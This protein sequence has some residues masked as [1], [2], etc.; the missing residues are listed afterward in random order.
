M[1]SK[2]FSEFMSDGVGNDT[3]TQEDDVKSRN[4]ILS[5][6]NKLVTRE[7]VVEVVHK[8]VDEGDDDGKAT[9]DNR[10]NNF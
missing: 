4:Q 1:I 6:N 9:N 3:C 10:L 2:R 5:N 7:E 8:F